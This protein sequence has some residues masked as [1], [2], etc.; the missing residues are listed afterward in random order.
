MDGSEEVPA[1][2]WGFSAI[3]WEV[4]TAVWEV[5]ATGRECSAAAWEFPAAAREVSATAWELT[6]GGGSRADGVWSRTYGDWKFPDAAGAG[7]D[8]KR[9]GSIRHSYFT[10]LLPS[11]GLTDSS[12]SFRKCRQPDTQN[13][14]PL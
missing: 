1:T 5:L 8:W 14:F 11:G 9:Q 10:F 3:G 13:H 7:P 4:T 6:A 2:G 12:R